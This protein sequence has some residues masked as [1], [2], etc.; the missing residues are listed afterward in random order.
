[1]NVNPTDQL[2]NETRADFEEIR[3]G[4]S[5]PLTFNVVIVFCRD[6]SRLVYTFSV[7]L[8]HIFKH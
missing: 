7:L 2:S 1:M 8:L 5:K 6:E 4:E 3:V